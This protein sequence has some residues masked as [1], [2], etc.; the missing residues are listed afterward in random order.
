MD[1]AARRQILGDLGIVPWQL[2]AVPGDEAA[3]RGRS[4][5]GPAREPVS[6]QH[7]AGSAPRT[8]EQPPDASAD[9]V[10][11]PSGA[12]GPRQRPDAEPRPIEQAVDEAF[13]VLSLVSGDALMLV[14]G[15]ASRRDLRLAM[16]VLAA[17][18]GDL[19]GRPL[20]RKFEWPP[21]G[22]GIGFHAGEAAARRALAA[23]VDKDVA[24]HG[25]RRVL[26]TPEVA[27]RWTAEATDVAL[28]DMPSLSALGQD[29][30]AKRE[31]WRRLR[32]GA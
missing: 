29:P 13:S 30:V 26:R 22:D 20:S 31:L 32:A 21:S 18:G 27:A 28:M 10:A 1:A 25:V 17:A 2:R 12:D 23:F 7:A 14:D 24:D 8:A 19:A 11:P 4:E 6:R 3:S 5:A 15:T 16:D 9:V